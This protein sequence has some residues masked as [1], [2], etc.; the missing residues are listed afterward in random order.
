MYSSLLIYRTRVFCVLTALEKDLYISR[1]LFKKVILAH[2]LNGTTTIFINYVHESKGF[3]N[4]F[5]S[6][7]F[8]HS[9]QLDESIFN[10]MVV[11]WHFSFLSK[12]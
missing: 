7:V 4:P 5:M 9:Y 1:I 3:V 2:I 11:G 10:G 6:N 12:F 8:S